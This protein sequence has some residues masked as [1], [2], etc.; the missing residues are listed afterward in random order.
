MEDIAE[1]M[2]SDDIKIAEVRLF[3]PKESKDVLVDCKGRVKDIQSFKDELLK[4]F[5]IQTKSK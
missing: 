4:N 5:S 3:K 1:E 2:L